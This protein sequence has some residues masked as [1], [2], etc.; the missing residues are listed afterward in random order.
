MEKLNDEIRQE[1]TEDERAYYDAKD[2]FD[3]ETKEIVCSY[4]K[5]TA[6]ELEKQHIAAIKEEY[7]GRM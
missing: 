7:R 4:W 6:I 5:K 3:A 2:R 1:M